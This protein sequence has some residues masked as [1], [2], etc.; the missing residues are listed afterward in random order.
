[1]KS[2]VKFSEGHIPDGKD[3]PVQLDSGVLRRLIHPHLPVK[4]KNVALSLL[5][6]NPGDEVTPHFHKEREELYFILSGEGVAV[7]KNGDEIEEIKYEKNLAI[8]IPPNVIH[9]IKC[10]GSEPLSLLV[11]MAPPLPMED[12]QKA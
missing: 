3:K 10:V 1:M 4:S 5:V 9:D 2:T 11:I 6:M 7:H 12:S 8:H